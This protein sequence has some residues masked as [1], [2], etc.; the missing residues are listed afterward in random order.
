LVAGELIDRCIG[1]RK[2]RKYRSL[3]NGRSPAVG[4]GATPVQFCNEA[5]RNLWKQAAYRMQPFWPVA[6]K[7]RRNR[8]PEP[9]HSQWVVWMDR[10]QPS[11]LCLMIGLRVERG[12][13]IRTGNLYVNE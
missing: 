7:I 5:P 13:L 2:M 11:D 8:I 6:G 9:R 1:L 4:R 10:Y 12:K 3:R